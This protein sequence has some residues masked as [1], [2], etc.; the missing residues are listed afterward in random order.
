MSKLHPSTIPILCLT[1]YLAL[2]PPGLAQPH[3]DLHLE[4]VLDLLYASR[5]P[6]SLKEWLQRAEGHE[7]SDALRSAVADLEAEVLNLKR[8]GLDAVLSW[9]SHDLRSLCAWSEEDEPSVTPAPLLRAS[10]LGIFLR[11][12]SLSFSKLS[13]EEGAAWWAG[14]DAWCG[15]GRASSSGTGSRYEKARMRADYQTSRSEL[16][17]YELDTETSRNRPQYALLHQA[18]LDYEAGGLEAALQAIEEAT[19]IARNVGDA[20]CLAACASL[21]QRLQAAPGRRA[22]RRTPPSIPPA[23]SLDGRSPYDLLWDIQHARHNDAPVH[24]L[25]TT[26]YTAQAM[27]QSSRDSSNSLISSATLR[28]SDYD[29]S[30]QA[31]SAALWLDMSILHLARL[32]ENLALEFLDPEQ[33]AWD[34]RLAILSRQAVRLAQQ[35]HPEQAIRLLL[36][37]VESHSKRRDMGVQEVAAWK[38][39]LLTCAL[40]EAERRRDEPTARSIAALLPHNPPDTSKTPSPFSDSPAH[41]SPSTLLASSLLKYHTSSAQS[42]SSSRLSSLCAI[43]DAR[44]A[45]SPTPEEAARG[46]A[47]L[48]SAWGEVLARSD[49]GQVLARA[50][51]AR[52]RAGVIAAGEDDAA[53][54][55]AID[56]LVQALD[57]KLAPLLFPAFGRVALE[58]ADAWSRDDRLAVYTSLDLHSSSQSLLVTLARLCDHLAHA[59]SAPLPPTGTWLSQRDAFAARYVSS[60]SQPALSSSPC[61]SWPR[62]KAAADHVSLAVEMAVRSP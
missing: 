14:F 32:R 54:A 33:P 8:A 62:L 7:P 2:S 57:S 55:A 19:Q 11:R 23:S 45:V 5:Q 16:R 60:S 6:P 52:G 58:D 13:F 31:A 10:P 41:P 56:C 22:T 1:K 44:I 25:F 36:H 21:R 26:L 18:L 35:N 53:V 42:L 12:A 50:W 29:A 38:R 20:G 59:P 49:E 3:L 30:W 34:V 48:E 46:L 9:I 4:F 27:Q 24:T 40:I 15:D 43:V 51:E 17:S 47:E 61:S 28:D 37:A 39:T